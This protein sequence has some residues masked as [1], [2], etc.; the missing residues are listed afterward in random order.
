MDPQFIKSCNN[1]AHNSECLGEG[2]CAKCTEDHRFYGHGL[3]GWEPRNRYTLYRQLRDQGLTY[4]EI[5]EK[6]GVSKQAV[7]IACRAGN[8]SWFR[9]FKDESCVYPR[10]KDWLNANKVSGV[11]LVSLMGDIANSHRVPKWYAILR[12]ERELAKS[13]IDN[14]IKVTGMTYEEL[15][16]ND[17]AGN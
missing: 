2:I 14:L 17:T 4:R 6:C 5:A 11:A 7:H 10:L 8:T 16:A 3:T 12:G 9:P 13:D 1:C 15:F